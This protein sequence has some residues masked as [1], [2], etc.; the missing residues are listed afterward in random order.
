MVSISE[1][2]SVSA[3][4][5]NLSTKYLLMLDVA[6]PDPFAVVTIGGEQTKTTSVIERTLNPYWN[7]SFNLWVHYPIKHGVY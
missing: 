5:Y 7:E 6:F 2:S 3:V 1:I 4:N